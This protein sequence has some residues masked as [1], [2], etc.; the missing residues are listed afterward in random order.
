V[1]HSIGRREPGTQLPKY[2]LQ[3]LIGPTQ[4]GRTAT[5]LRNTAHGLRGQ[6]LIVLRGDFGF[7]CLNVGRIVDIVAETRVVAG[8][9]HTG[10]VGTNLCASEGRVR[11]GEAQYRSSQGSSGDSETGNHLVHDQYS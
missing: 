7:S 5:V 8:L 6:V 10:K 4:L 1:A 3:K 9:L 2:T 11:L